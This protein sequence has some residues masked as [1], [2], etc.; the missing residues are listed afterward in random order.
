MLS[1]VLKVPL[2]A[3][4]LVSSSGLLSWLQGA[5]ITLPPPPASQDTPCELSKALVALLGDVWLA[6]TMPS[7]V[8]NKTKT[9]K[10]FQSNIFYFE[11]LKIKCIRKHLK[12][13]MQFKVICPKTVLIQVKNRVKSKKI[14]VNRLKARLL[15]SLSWSA[16]VSPTLCSL[17]C[18]NC[19]LEFRCSC[20]C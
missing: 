3:W 9:P 14:S 17:C 4:R 13:T 7:Q 8:R 10:Y 5:V 15:V 18:L 19:Q 16:Q 6:A 12:I 11:Y 2:A 1:A 20:P